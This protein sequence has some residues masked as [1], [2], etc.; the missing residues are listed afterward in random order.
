MEGASEYGIE[1]EGNSTQLSVKINR[2]SLRGMGI[3]VSKI[4]Q[5]IEAAIGAQRISTP[6]EGP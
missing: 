2:K 6:Y 1:Q 5:V 4:Q 3:N